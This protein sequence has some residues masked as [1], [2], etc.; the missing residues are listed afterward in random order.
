MEKIK[1]TLVKSLIKRTVR[2]KRTIEALG[3]RKINHSVVKTASPQISGMIKTVNHLIK[4]E[5]AE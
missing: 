1:I 4:T 5:K 2:Q 3:L